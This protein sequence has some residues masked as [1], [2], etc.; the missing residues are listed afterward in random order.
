M[1]VNETLGEYV[2]HCMCMEPSY[3]HGKLFGLLWYFMDC[4]FERGLLLRHN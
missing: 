4:V 1:S 2:P 3:L